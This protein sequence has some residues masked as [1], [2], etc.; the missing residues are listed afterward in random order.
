MSLC[1]KCG[2]KIGIFDYGYN[3]VC[4]M[5]WKETTK[6]EKTNNTNTL[7]ENK[8]SSSNKNSK[9]FEGENKVAIAV[10]IIA[11]IGGIIGILN[12]LN[13]GDSGY[14]EELGVTIVVASII[15]AVFIY[16]FG[17]II[18][19]LQNIEDNIRK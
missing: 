18:Q 9:S 19:K 15:S 1:K 10:K 13:L 11:I 4:E 12:G 16:G 17:E 2:R 8:S 7:N 5:C 6:K 14:T 3:G